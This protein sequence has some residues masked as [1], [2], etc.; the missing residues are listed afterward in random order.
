MEKER[1][2]LL[3]QLNKKPDTMATQEVYR[4]YLMRRAIENNTSTRM[5][6]LST[7]L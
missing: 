5:K 4:E 6:K 1:G 3:W 2:K 7:R